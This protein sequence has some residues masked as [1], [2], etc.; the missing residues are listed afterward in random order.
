MI[1]V[2]EFK[3]S[4]YPKF[5]AEGFAAQFAFPF[6]KH[7]CKGDGLDIGYNK[8]E[9]KLPGALGVEKGRICTVDGNEIPT[10]YSDALHLPQ[11]MPPADYIFSSHCLE[12]LP[13]WIGVLDHWNNSLKK[14]G[15]LFLYLPDF[16]QEYWRPWNNRK[17]F[18][19]FLPNIIYQ[20]LKER[21]FEKVFV[22][23]AD[24][25]SSFIAMAEK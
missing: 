23:D 11:D 21:N 18:H 5:Q 15:T 19:A 25:N 12:H 8:P 10:P 20:Y 6:A 1:E 9:W 22:S 2:I 17:H 7:V 3:D 4:V 16:S 24:M 14:G 13:D